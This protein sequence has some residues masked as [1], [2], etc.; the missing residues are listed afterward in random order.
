MFNRFQVSR[1]L[2]FTLSVVTV[3]GSGLRAQQIPVKVWEE[4]VTL[5]TY[6]IGEPLTTPMFYHG[7]AYQGAQGHFYPYPVQDK[8]T[9]V[10]KNQSH[11]M[12]YLENRY[13]KIGVLPEIGGRVFYALDKTDNYKFL[14]SASVVKPGL[15]GML[16]AWLDGG[17]EWNVPHHHRPSVYLPVQY[18]LEK[19]PDGSA[20]IWVGELEINHRMRWLIGLTL[21]PDTSYLEGTFKLMNESAAANSFLYFANFGVPASQDYRI[22]FPPSTEVGTYHAKT[23]FI[24]WP[25]ADGHYQGIDFTGEDVSLWKTHIEMNS[26]FAY[27]CIEDWFGGYD[28]AKQ[29]GVL[30]FADHHV[31]PGKKFWTWGA[32]EEGQMW[33]KLLTEPAD[34]PVME[35]MA[36]SY[37]DNE[38]DY[39][40]IQPSEVKT[41]KQFWYPFQKIGIVR[42]ANLQAAVSLAVTPGGAA[43]IGLYTTSAHRAAKVLLEAS[44][45]V[46]FEKTISIDPATPF[47]AQVPLPQGTQEKELKVRLLDGS[48]E[49]ISYQP[50]QRKNLPLPKP[51]LPPADP[52]SIATNEQ[53]YLTGLRLQQFFNPAAEPYPW[54]DAVLKRDPGDDRANTELG[55]LFYKRGMFEEAEQRLSAAAA[56]VTSNYTRPKDGEPLYYLGLAQ[57]A[58]GEFDAAYKTL[59]DATW[60]FAWA[61]P[62]YYGLAELACMKHDYAHALDFLDRSLA[63]NTS[64]AKALNLKASILRKLGREKDAGAVSA[65]A[66]AVDPLD[67]WAQR[68]LSLMHEQKRP[69]FLSPGQ[70]ND[71]V[72]P[73]LEMAVNL[74][75]AGLWD[76]G[77]AALNELVSAYP[78]KMRV[79]PMVYY[80]LASMHEK[81]GHDQEAARC[82]DL[83]R[84]MP[85]DYCFPFRVESIAVLRRAME[86]NPKDARA[87]FYL[88]D[89][90]DDRQPREA[91]KA[92]ELARDL[93]PKF[94]MV[95]RNLADAYAWTEQDYPKAVRSLQTAVA[96]DPL[97]KF[98]AELDEFS[99]RA[100]V[101]PAQRLQALLQHQQAVLE[102][103]DALTREIRLYVQLGQYDK[104]L[105]LLL[106]G[107]HYTIWEGGRQYPAHSSYQSAMLLSGHESARAGNYREALKRYQAALEYPDNFSEGRPVDGGRAPVVYYFIATAYEALS[108]SGNARAFL[109]KAAAPPS[110][111]YRPS[112]IA[113][114]FRPEIQYYRA[115]ALRKL[116]RGPAADRIFAAL[117]ASGEEALHAAPGGRPDFFAKFGE[118]ETEADRLAQGHY[119]LGLGYLGT[120]QRQ[121][122]LAQMQ[123][124]VN[125]NV[126]HLEAQV[127]L[128]GIRTP[129]Q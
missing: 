52:A 51:T 2:L 84:R 65:A 56:R 66:L 16:G 128:A 104:A 72:Q 59:F 125:L 26:I 75:G 116:G 27:D 11:K 50:Y 87:P 6:L 61:A 18:K 45:K 89:L 60:S 63:A 80:W 73:Y 55:I 114:E 86:R 98:M 99:E 107:H 24:R 13:V 40:W 96:L 102:R 23:D 1:L 35:L 22:L 10:R 109:E 83:A 29:A 117:V 127:Q 21:H 42:N 64:N 100:L 124:A 71:D 122:A 74:A 123:E 34:G 36:G 19:N 93:D 76:E 108:D 5:P 113:E 126:N 120:G 38:P 32:G 106:N 9:Y 28:H 4:Q 82:Y 88:G 57:K 101:P 115:Q 8:L 105:A 91:I 110:P 33:D 54:F 77:I 3:F 90:L 129:A 94:P 70:W 25:I 81:A 118:R 67:V 111:K 41:V 79:H 58:R 119:V 103:D 12:L 15:V 53:T 43:S 112:Y 121:E 62:S 49:L 97:P 68:E 95:H 69:I 37:S 20:T 78:D 44:G 92:W 31:S 48:E 46:L 17:I 30:Y 85:A 7:R 14:Y 47:L 39:S